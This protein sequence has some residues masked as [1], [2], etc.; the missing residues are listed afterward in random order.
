VIDVEQDA[1]GPLEQ[2]SASSDASLVEIAPNGAGERKDEVCDLLQIIEKAFAID[3][4]FAEARPQRIVVSAK[5][6]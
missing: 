1:L 5:A 4:R 2:D 6:I 3:G